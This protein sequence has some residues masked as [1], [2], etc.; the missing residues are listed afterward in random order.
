MNLHSKTLYI[1]SDKTNINKDGNSL[2]ITCDDI[3][4]QTLPIN[5]I[6][7]VCV[8]GY[9]SLT[10]SALNLCWQNGI[11]VT[12]ISSSGKVLAQLTSS[13]SNKYLI[14]NKQTILSLNKKFCA[15]VS[16][17]IVKAKIRSMLHLLQ[18][19]LRILPHDKNACNVKEFLLG[20]IG[21]L[22]DMQLKYKKNMHARILGIEGICSKRYFSWLGSQIKEKYRNDFAFNNRS[23][24]PPLDNFNSILSFLYSLLLQDCIAALINVGLE[25]GIGFLH[26]TQDGRPSLALDLME[27]FRPWMVDKLALRLVNK[28]QLNNNHFNPY[29]QGIYLNDAGKKITVGAY[30]KWKNRN[31]WLQG[32]NSKLPAWSVIFRQAEKLSDCVKNSFL[33]FA[34]AILR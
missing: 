10:S 28:N 20:M 21:I 14:K 29:K 26:I 17:S 15:R 2:K 27:E 4:N 1:T 16:V 24:R 34:P 13:N 30:H 5:A 22:D 32:N 33:D 9:N 11:S 7:N 19:S 31:V 8:I 23:K 6:S 25:P 12:Y 18:R 3:F